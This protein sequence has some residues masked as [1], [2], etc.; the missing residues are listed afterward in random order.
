MKIGEKRDF[1]R[2]LRFERVERESFHSVGERRRRVRVG[3]MKKFF[4]KK[5]APKGFC[6]KLQ[7]HPRVDPGGRLMAR[8][9]SK[10]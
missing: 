1:E 5:R 10:E 3:S 7:V 9:N 8:K 2:N 6:Q 4:N